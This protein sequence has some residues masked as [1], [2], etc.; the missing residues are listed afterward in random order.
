MYSFVLLRTLHYIASIRFRRKFDLDAAYRRCH[1]AGET[2]AECL[3]IY[4]DFLLMALR[5]TFGGAPCPPLWGHISG[6]IADLSNALIQDT[7]WDPGTLSDTLIDSLHHPSPPPI[8]IPFMQSKPMIIEI[9]KN[10]NGKT[11]V[12]IDDFINVTPDVS[13]NCRRTSAATILAIRSLSRPLDNSD[14]IPRKDII[15][16]KKFIA[17]GSLKETKTILGWRINSRSL[18]ISLPPEKSTKWKRKIN[19]LIY[20]WLWNTSFADNTE[21]IVQKTTARQL[22]K[23]ILKN[24]S[25]LYS[26]W[27]A[28]EQNSVSDALSRDFHLTDESPTKLILSSTPQQAPLPNFPA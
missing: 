16:L 12:Y 13:E 6:T 23:I 2:A 27:F 3:T 11:D 22:A 25:C 8:G 28:G 7:S 15:S 21:E 17:E 14:P 9:P 4:N 26:Q 5:M 20:G 24:N 10:D 1:L 18:V 19:K